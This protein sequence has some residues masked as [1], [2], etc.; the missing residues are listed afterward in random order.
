METKSTK[1]DD[2]FW[3]AL[4]LNTTSRIAAISACSSYRRVAELEGEGRKNNPELPYDT[5]HVFKVSSGLGDEVDKWLKSQGLSRK[6]NKKI[7]R[8]LSAQLLKML[9]AG[10]KGLK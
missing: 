6:Q 4:G 1:P 3:F 2:E 7:I 8:Q 5:F 10:A 9:D